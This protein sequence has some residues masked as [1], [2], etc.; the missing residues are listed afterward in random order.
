MRIDFRTAQRGYTLVFSQNLLGAY[1]PCRRWFWLANKRGG[2]KQQ[3]FV[4]EEKAMREFGQISRARI[5]NR[6]ELVLA[7]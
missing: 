1:V 7:S 3:A 2:M 5:R 6:Y 4:A